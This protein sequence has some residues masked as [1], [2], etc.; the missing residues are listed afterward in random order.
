MSKLCWTFISDSYLSVITHKWSLTGSKKFLVP[1]YSGLQPNLSVNHCLWGFLSFS[2][3]KLH[4]QQSSTKYSVFQWFPVWLISSKESWSFSLQIYNRQKKLPSLYSQLQRSLPNSSWSHDWKSWSRSNPEWLFPLLS[5]AQI[6]S[7]ELRR[8]SIYS[9][10][11][12]HADASLKSVSRNETKSVTHLTLKVKFRQNFD[13][14][15]II[16]KAQNC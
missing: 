15:A 13:A 12:D 5:V 14:T 9:T 10:G 16:F 2:V 7:C 1:H 11:W 8:V 6:L 4:H 3:I